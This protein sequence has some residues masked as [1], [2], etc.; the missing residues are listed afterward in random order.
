MTHSESAQPPEPPDFKAAAP[1][2]GV[3]QIPNP[4][5]DDVK[6]YVW[7]FHCAVNPEAPA[8]S[9]S[10]MGE[11]AI[12]MAATDVIKE[13]RASRKYG[14][15]AAANELRCLR[16]FVDTYTARDEYDATERSALELVALL[17]ADNQSLRV[18]LEAAKA[19]TERLD[20]L[21]RNPINTERPMKPTTSISRAQIDG[22]R[23]S[24]SGQ[25][26]TA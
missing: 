15:G 12:L 19:D 10:T 14:R 11:K 9:V 22:A 2:P 24:R 23:A 4:F 13:L 25:G 3:P 21:E 18:S 5:P 20:W 8:L 16:H 7:A 17:E 6:D 1:E 26:E